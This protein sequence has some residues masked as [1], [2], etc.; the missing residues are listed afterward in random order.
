MEDPV[1]LVCNHCDLVY[2]LKKFTP[3][4]VYTC[5]NCGRTLVFPGGNETRGY[6]PA[7]GGDGG[8][9]GDGKSWPERSGEGESPAEPERPAN[10]P[11]SA[12]ARA[13]AEL[14]PPMAAGVAPE[15][16][17]VRLPKLIEQ[18]VE[19][20]DIVKGLDLQATENSPSARILENTGRLERELREVQDSLAGK[21]G[22]LDAR[23]GA[24]FG[25]E[26]EILDRT[27]EKRL[28]E[29]GKRL[30]ETID[31]RLAA[32]LEGG[33]KELRAGNSGFGERLDELK[34]VLDE[35][36]GANLD[37][38]IAGQVRAA[39]GEALEEKIG[40]NLDEKLADK[41]GE[42]LEVTLDQKME[43]RLGNDPGG[44]ARALDK[45]LGDLGDKFAEKLHTNIREL[46]GNFE[47][48]LADLDDKF[49]GKIG[50]GF[51]DINSALDKKLGFFDQKLGDAIDHNLRGVN[52]E[53]SR[54]INNLDAK[55]S[56]AVDSGLGQS[57]ADLHR[58]VQTVTDKLAAASGQS[59]ALSSMQQEL[60]D[61]HNTLLSRLEEHRA[62]QKSDLH[63]LFAHAEAQDNA[64]TVEVNIDELADRLVAGVRKHG[65]LLD[66]ES[67]GAVDAMVKLAEELVKEQNNNSERL[68]KNS[69]RLDK[70]AGE[71]RA[72]VKSIDNFE[73]WQGGLPGRVADEIGQTVEARVV[74][75]ISGALAKQAPSILSEL[76]DNKLVDIVSRSVREAQRPL[77]RE[78]LAGGRQ[79]VPVWLFA[80]VLLP[81]LLILG[82]LFL[83]GEYVGRDQSVASNEV[84]DAIA[85]METNGVP[86]AADTE[87][88]LRNIE[89]AVLDIH[90]EAL[91]HVKNASLLEGEL[92]NLKAA[93]AERDQL[94]KDY[95]ET[96]QNQVKRLRAYEMRLI[97]LGV[98]PKTVGE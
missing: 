89:D 76:Q 3:G 94:I 77:L 40:G 26:P 48:R 67:G 46:S 37:A 12:T 57:L 55:M 16:G 1:R 17:L 11:A 10:T 50:G 79:G 14:P 6:D 74:G 49:T 19:R 45:R 64:T 30:D 2:R 95:N 51:H 34:S 56:S 90:S 86:L 13:F 41:I 27:L 81:L 69:E 44:L 18:L 88:R 70:L 54:R 38:K 92:K 97:Q 62:A 82:Y 24:K 84:G 8:D 80:S 15:S 23:L 91:A 21:L 63:T 29:F 78:I 83:P 43:K 25:A 98:S 9:S 58:K 53:I 5:K 28:E 66:P 75:P 22:E 59:A 32:K 20:L 96:L 4:R 31:A 36:F 73:E 68:D 61:A 72:A 42:K 47:R 35:R 65:P 85:R 87:D 7:S 33:L 93:L 60:K 39:L 71:I 52:Q